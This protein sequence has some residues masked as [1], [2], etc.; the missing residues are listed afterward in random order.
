MAIVDT[1]L[2]GICNAA[3]IIVEF[4]IQLNTSG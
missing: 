3:L 4:V 1:Q 2:S